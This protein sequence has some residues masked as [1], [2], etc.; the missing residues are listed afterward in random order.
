M[1]GKLTSLILWVIVLCTPLHGA[2]S[3]RNSVI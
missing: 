3:T 2:D 1:I